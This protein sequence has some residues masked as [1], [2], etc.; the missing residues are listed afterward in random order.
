MSFS[1]DPFTS[2][3]ICITLFRF[4]YEVIDL[5]CYPIK[6]TYFDY[7]Y[8]VV[9]HIFCFRKETFFQGVKR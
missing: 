5:I 8:L 1:S 3:V 4:P 7:I 9:H 6:P 2:Y